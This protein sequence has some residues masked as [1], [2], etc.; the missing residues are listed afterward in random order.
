[1]KLGDNTTY[2][3]Q[4]EFPTLKQRINNYELLC[5]LLDGVV[6]SDGHI[7]PG[8]FKTC[9]RVTQIK[10]HID[11]L[12]N[13]QERL[14]SINIKSRIV[15]LVAKSNEQEKVQLIT[16]SS[17]LFMILRNRWYKNNIKI[18]PDDLKISSLILADWL[19]GDGSTGIFKRS[20]S[21][22]VHVQLY[23][24]SFTY[25]ELQDLQNRLYLFSFNIQ[26]V[27]P[28]QFI[29]SLS[30]SKYVYLFLKLVEPYITESFKYKLKYPDVISLS[31]AMKKTNK[32]ER[33]SKGRFIKN[34]K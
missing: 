11:W 1:M 20:P 33:N 17:E 22:L 34:E 8:K 27:R 9:L 23:T 30:K 25:Q 15:P 21:K 31:Q 26:E 18:V 13:I 3:L 6:I 32:R 29:L 19:M 14:A 10:L 4:K 24:N 16:K 5:Q 28:N 7:N 2:L 12:E